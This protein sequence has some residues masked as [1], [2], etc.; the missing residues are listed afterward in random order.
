M[1]GRR[2]RK[3]W[4]S[5]GSFT[6]AIGSWSRARAGSAARELIYA[7]NYNDLLTFLDT[8]SYGEQS[9]SGLEAAKREWDRKLASWE[10]HRSMG[11]GQQA[12]TTSPDDS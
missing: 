9:T 12:R 1:P 2:K 3:C 10:W 6:L 8:L 4:R 5:T 7:K 11:F